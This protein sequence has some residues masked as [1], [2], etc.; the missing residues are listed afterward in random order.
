ML[1][2]DYQYPSQS[3]SRI[4][5]EN[6]LV[7]NLDRSDSASIEISSG[8]DAVHDLWIRHNTILHGAGGNRVMFIG[9]RKPSVIGFE[10]IDNIVT[11]GR[12]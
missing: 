9:S 3:T 6:N 12:D 7:Y 10:F 8:G 2:A 4:L 11:H 1:G 5:I